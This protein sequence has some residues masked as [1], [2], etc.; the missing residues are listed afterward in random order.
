MAPL[1]LVLSAH[2]LEGPLD[3][4]ASWVTEGINLDD[5]IYPTT[6]SLNVN[7]QYIIWFNNLDYQYNIDNKV[8]VLLRISINLKSKPKI[9]GIWPNAYFYE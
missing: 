5:L 1:T 3:L 7:M 6:K 8:F 2:I 4:K 9:K